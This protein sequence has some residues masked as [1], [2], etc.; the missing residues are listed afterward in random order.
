M[1]EKTKVRVTVTWHVEVDETDMEHLL[2]N[3]AD[4]E[5]FMAARITGEE[6]FPEQP[7]AKKVAIQIN[8]DVGNISQG[9][10]C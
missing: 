2:Q 7:W 5:S 1:T 6:N 4:V 8:D 3:P 10:A 9:R